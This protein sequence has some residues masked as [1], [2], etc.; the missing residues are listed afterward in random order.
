MTAGN[1]GM[2]AL[3]GAAVA[4]LLAFLPFSTVLGGA[5]AGYLQH[6][7]YRD[8]AV[9]GALAGLIALLPILALGSIFGGVLLMGPPVGM[10]HGF[11]AVGFV[12]LFLVFF[13]A[14]IYFLGLGALGGVLGAYIVTETELGATD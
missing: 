14:M 9:V 6:G 7:D 13:F 3:I 10:P 5:V 2:N 11:A 1:T 8:G 4:V 12:V